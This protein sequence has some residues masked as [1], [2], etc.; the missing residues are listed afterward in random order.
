MNAP[1]YFGTRLNTQ[2]VLEKLSLRPARRIALDAAGRTT[3]PPFAN[4][5]DLVTY[6]AIQ[7]RKAEAEGLYVAEKMAKLELVRPRTSIQRTG[8]VLQTFSGVTVEGRRDL[9]V[10]A[11]HTIPFQ[12]LFDMTLPY[13]LPPPESMQLTHKFQHR[14]MLLYAR[15]NWQPRA[16][17][18]VDSALEGSSGFVED[19]YLTALKAVIAGNK[20]DDVYPAYSAAKRKALSS[21]C[22]VMNSNGFVTAGVPMQSKRQDTKQIVESIRDQR[23]TIIEI[24]AEHERASPLKIATGELKLPIESETWLIPATS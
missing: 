7:K 15:C 1:I 22:D 6:H 23:E 18:D 10:H 20:A 5:N 13:F 17:N 24:Y 19:L 16:V 14:N 2:D 11:C 9:D 12:A 4:F 21:L 8:A 3:R